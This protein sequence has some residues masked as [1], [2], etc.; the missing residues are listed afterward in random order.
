MS[1]PS[2]I[3]KAFDTKHK[4]WKTVLSTKDEAKAEAMKEAMVQ[5]GVKAEIETIPPKR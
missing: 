1:A 4:V 5:D 3:V 2:Y